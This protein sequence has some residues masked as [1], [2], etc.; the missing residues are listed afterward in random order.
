[1]EKDVSADGRNCDTLGFRCG[2]GGVSQIHQ[3]P[4]NAFIAG[5]KHFLGKHGEIGYAGMCLLCP[6]V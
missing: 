1:M 4:V 2:V 5:K 3:R 6:Q